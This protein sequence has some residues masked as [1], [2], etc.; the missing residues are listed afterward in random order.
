M[1]TPQNTTARV[2][3]YSSIVNNKPN[4]EARV[5][6]QAS[7]DGVYI[8]LAPPRHTG[9]VVPL[10]QGLLAAASTITSFYI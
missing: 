2:V 8:E 10:L 9:P 4:L 1:V 6:Q 5:A 7:R 3:A